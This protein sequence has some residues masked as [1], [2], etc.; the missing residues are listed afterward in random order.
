[1]RLFEQGRT[2][3]GEVSGRRSSL[4]IMKMRDSYLPFRDHVI[5][6]RSWHIG[7]WLRG[8]SCLHGPRWAGVSTSCKKK[9]GIVH[10]DTVQCGN[11]GSYQV[12]C[13]SS[14]RITISL[15]WNLSAAII[16]LKLRDV[17]CW[18]LEKGLSTLIYFSKIR[19]ILTGIFYYITLL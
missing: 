19:G 6:T 15:R 3:V 14:V 16:M 18:S 9:G 5:L 4:F 1:M 10:R 12:P 17:L 11:V 8:K 7:G 2:A 13:H